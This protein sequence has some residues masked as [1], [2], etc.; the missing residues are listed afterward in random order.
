MTLSQTNFESKDVP[1]ARHIP[2]PLSPALFAPPELRSGRLHLPP[3]SAQGG[4]TPQQGQGQSHGT[5][6]Q[7]CLLFRCSQHDGGK[8]TPSELLIQRSNILSDITTRRVSPRHQLRHELSQVHPRGQRLEG[9]RGWGPWSVHGAR[10]VGLALRSWLPSELV[11]CR[12][13]P[14]RGARPRRVFR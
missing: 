7:H 10:R 12:N 2:H 9:A 8:D 5:T 14:N 6:P 13:R 11:T 4:V 3:V 1:I